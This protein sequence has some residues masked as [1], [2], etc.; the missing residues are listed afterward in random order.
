MELFSRTPVYHPDLYSVFAIL[1]LIAVVVSAF[2]GGVLGGLTSAVIAVLY[3][4]YFLSIPGELFHYTGRDLRRTIVLGAVLPPLALLVGYLRERVDQLLRRERGLRTEAEAHAAASQELAVELEM[5]N[6]ELR[7][8][9]EEAERANQAKSDFL[10]TMS[11]ELRTPL[12]AILGFADL[13]EAGVPEPIP[14]A[15]RTQVERIERSARH[16][17][18]LIDEILTLSRV[19]AGREEI[20]V[21]TVPLGTLVQEAVSTVEPLVVQKDLSC[22]VDLSTAPETMETDRRK[23]FQILLNLL[24]N[25]VKFT[26]KGVVELA[27]WS[28]GEDVVFRVRDTGIGISPEQQRRLFEPFWQANQSKTRTVGGSGLGLA[29][30]Q[31]LVHLLGGEIS[32]ESTLNL[33]STF[34]IRLPSNSGA[35]SQNVSPGDPFVEERHH[36]IP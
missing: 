2:L 30:T 25:A 18:H 27:V 1:L 28:D 16:L 15:S 6:D 22:R 19:E 34:T 10:A 23:V 12:N 35:R 17:L 32:V 31:K 14:E 33:G 9:K 21:E 29:V 8:A 11:H 26:E 4:A 36:A 13:L 7:Q 24:G 3:N 20:H 5:S